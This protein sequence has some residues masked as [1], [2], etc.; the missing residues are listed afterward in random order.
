LGSKIPGWILSEDHEESVPG[1]P[2]EVRAVL[3]GTYMDAVRSFD[4]SGEWE[5]AYTGGRPYRFLLRA[6]D[7]LLF[8]WSQRG[9]YGEHQLEWCK[10][11]PGVVYDGPIDPR[12]PSH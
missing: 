12:L 11:H 7:Y 6:G 8:V 9:R 4:P 1:A 5:R 3:Q 10:A 2:I